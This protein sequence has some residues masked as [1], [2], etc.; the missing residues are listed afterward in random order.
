MQ[1]WRFNQRLF[2]IKEIMK[3]RDDGT[4]KD[5]SFQLNKQL[6]EN[7]GTDAVMEN[8]ESWFNLQ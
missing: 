8:F 3:N 7:I 6:L 4:V 5:I 2:V 1:Q